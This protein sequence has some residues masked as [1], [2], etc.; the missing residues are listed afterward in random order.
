ML[1]AKVRMI[2]HGTRD[3]KT[4][5]VLLE[6]PAELKSKYKIGPLIGEGNFA[7]VRQCLDK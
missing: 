6:A 4:I 1:Q 2:L 7:T 5:E 3:Q